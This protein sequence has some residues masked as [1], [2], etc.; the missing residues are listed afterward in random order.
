MVAVC[1]S[2]GRA[3]VER[4]KSEG[5]AKEE[6]RS[7]EGW[8]KVEQAVGFEIWC[9][10]SACFGNGQ[11]LSPPPTHSEVCSPLMPVNYPLIPHLLL[12]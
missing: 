4:R 12:Y 10:G 5:R 6:R 7:S 8:A 2:E 1:E 3:K 9:K 11:I